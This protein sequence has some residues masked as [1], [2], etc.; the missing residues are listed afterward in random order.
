M[1]CLH[2]HGTRYSQL[3]RGDLKFTGGG[4]EVICKN[5][6]IL[7]KGLE[8]LLILMSLR[9]GGVLELIPCGYRGMALIPRGTRHGLC[10]CGAQ[11]LVGRQTVFP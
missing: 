1:I 2:F 5:Y 10:P 9:R 8:H 3:S 11:G 6:G 4:A 7:C